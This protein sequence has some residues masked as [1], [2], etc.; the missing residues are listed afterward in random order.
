MKIL[1]CFFF[2]VTLGYSLHQAIHL[3][4]EMPEG[5]DRLADYAIGTQGALPVFAIFLKMLG[6]SNEQIFKAMLA[7]EIA[8]LM[9]GIGVAGG[10]WTDTLI[11]R[12]K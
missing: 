4:R 12:E 10:W 7:F 9:I 5:W 11:N 2:P 3:T 1:L 6:F 8:F